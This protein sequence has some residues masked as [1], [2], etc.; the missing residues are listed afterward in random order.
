MVEKTLSPLPIQFDFETK[1]V[2]RKLTS[3][4]RVFYTLI[5]L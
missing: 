3:A 2:F 5:L 1:A 4:H